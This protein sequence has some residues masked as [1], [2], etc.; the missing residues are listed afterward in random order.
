[1]SDCLQPYGLEHTRLLCPWNSPGKN[2]G[3]G[4]PFLPP[5]DLTDPVIECISLMSP[6]LAGRFFTTS[7]TWEALKMVKMVNFTLYVFYH[8]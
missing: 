6:A 2:T 4:L 1:M 7:A 8:S 5:G 3:S